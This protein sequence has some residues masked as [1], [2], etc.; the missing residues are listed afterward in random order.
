M[1]Q[2]EERLRDL[3]KRYL[4]MIEEIDKSYLRKLQVT[5]QLLVYEVMPLFRKYLSF[6]KTKFR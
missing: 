3:E 5:N 2:H 4:S 6:E 1:E